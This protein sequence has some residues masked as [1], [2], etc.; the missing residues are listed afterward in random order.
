MATR[1][2]RIALALELK[3]LHGHTTYEVEH[4]EDV[5]GIPAGVGG[6]FTQVVVISLEAL[7]L[8]AEDITAAELI[9]SAGIDERNEA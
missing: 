9:E 6:G 7:G 8:T 2:E 5:D 4:T 1:D 3:Q